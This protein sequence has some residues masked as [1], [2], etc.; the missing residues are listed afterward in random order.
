MPDIGG[1]FR[2]LPARMPDSDDGLSGLPE[3]T[4][5]TVGKLPCLQKETAA[6][7]SGSFSLPGVTPGEA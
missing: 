6:N 3:N 5:G 1:C 7:L 4:P 2:Q